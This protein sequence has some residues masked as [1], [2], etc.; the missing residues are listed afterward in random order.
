MTSSVPNA[1]KL[2]VELAVESPV[3]H[4]VDL[5][6]VGVITSGARAPLQGAVA[7]IDRLLG[8]RVERMRRDHGDAES[9]L[10]DGAPAIKAR[11]VLLLWLGDEATLD[12]ARL[13]DAASRAVRRALEVGARAVGFAPGLHDAGV[14]K[15]AVDAVARAV[16]SGARA[17]FASA[18]DTRGDLVFALEVSER[19]RALA[20]E[21]LSS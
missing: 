14:T 16:A 12:L 21:G 18:G 5:V 15:L 8:G 19:N 1:P 2:T 11:R 13:E 9:V 3:V 17:A 20:A 4:D 6:A 7:E 10:V